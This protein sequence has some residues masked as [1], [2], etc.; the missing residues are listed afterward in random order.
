MCS[1]SKQNFG[2]LQPFLWKCPL[3]CKRP[4]YSWIL[5]RCA[6]GAAQKLPK[7]YERLVDVMNLCM[8]WCCYLYKIPLELV[9][10][11]DETFV[12]Y[13]PMGMATTYD[14]R[15]AKHVC[16][17]NLLGSL[18]VLAC[19]EDEMGQIVQVNALMNFCDGDKQPL[20]VGASH[21]QGGQ[22]WPHNLRHNN[23]RRDCAGAAANLRRPE[24]EEPA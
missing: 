20:N 21:R 9:F 8:A 22:A 24:G 13:T 12:W 2:R 5:H 14:I 16:S 15:N 17:S 7:D 19:H 11:M 3:L 1:L 10:S 23:A 18:T 4:K 6:T